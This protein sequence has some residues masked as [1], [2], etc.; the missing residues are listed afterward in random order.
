MKKRLTKENIRDYFKPISNR[1]YEKLLKLYLN[2]DFEANRTLSK[3]REFIKHPFR[4][5]NSIH[6]LVHTF[7]WN[8]FLSKFDIIH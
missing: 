8:L 1:K 6:G 4:M 2:K 5:C 3:T 7:N